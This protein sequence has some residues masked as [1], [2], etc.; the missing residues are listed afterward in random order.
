MVEFDLLE[1]MTMNSLKEG[2]GRVYT[3]ELSS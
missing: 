2:P 3:F 1:T